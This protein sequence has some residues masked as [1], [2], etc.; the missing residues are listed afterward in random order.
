MPTP[1]VHAHLLQRV[2]DKDFA[3]TDLD[4]K[5]RYFVAVSLTGNANPWLMELLEDRSL[6]QKKAEE[7][8]RACAALGLALR[9][10]APAVPVFEREVARSYQSDVVREACTWAL[11]HV[12]QPRDVR[13]RQLYDVLFR[14]TL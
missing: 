8:Q 13:T 2:K 6:L 9:M 12:R 5:R 10:H 14:G 4:E 1:Q 11:Q 7:E 3:Q